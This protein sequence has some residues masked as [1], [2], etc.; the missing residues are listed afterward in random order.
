MWMGFFEQ[1]VTVMVEV[2]LYKVGDPALK[3]VGLLCCFRST[4]QVPG[5][6]EV[7]P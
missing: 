4:R 7:Y 3:V 2:Q 6:E 1:H 5:A